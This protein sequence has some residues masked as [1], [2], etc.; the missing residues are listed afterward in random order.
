MKQKDIELLLEYLNRILHDESEAPLDAAMLDT[1]AQ[2]LARRLQEVQKKVYD[3]QEQVRQKA[4]HDAGTGVYNRLFFEEYLGQLLHEKRSAVVVYMDLD[5]LKMVNDCY[6]HSEG[7]AFIRRYVEA[8]QEQFRTTDVFARIGGDE[9]GL[10]LPEC[11][12]ALARTRLEQVREQ[13]EK[14]SETGYT[15]S[16]SYGMVEVNESDELTVEELLETADAAM[17]RYK[18]MKRETK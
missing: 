4:Y 5:S 2:E 7:D 18:H 6:G 13:L 14:N 3:L 11:S 10:V 17:Y 16:F 1:S 12:L 8:I 9:F 15:A